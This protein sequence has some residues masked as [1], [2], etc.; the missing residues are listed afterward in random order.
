MSMEGQ[1]SDL[2]WALTAEEFRK[3]GDFSGWSDEAVQQ[4]IETLTDLT[5]IAINLLQ[6]ESKKQKSK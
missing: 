4:A 2:P 3:S 1:K 5:I 6:L